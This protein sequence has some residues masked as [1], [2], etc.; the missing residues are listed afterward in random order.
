MT[1]LELFR[2]KA[3]WMLDSLKGGKVKKYLNE[4]K[5]IEGEDG[6]PDKDV[7]SYC[8]SLLK[9][10]LEHAGKTVPLYSGQKTLNIQDWP[11]T[12]KMTYREDYDKC[13]SSD[14]DKASLIEMSTSGSTGTPF[15][16][17]Q[18]GTKKKHVNA[19][20][21]FY[22]GKIGFE[23]GRRI[24]YLRSIVSEVQKSRLTQFLQNIYLLDCGDL[25]DEGIKKKL[26]RIVD[27][28]KGCGAMMMG[29]ASTF[30][31]FRRYFDKYGFKDA[32]GAKIYGIASGSEMLY[33]TTRASMEKAF[34]CKCVSRYANEENGFLGQDSKENN[35][36]YLNRADYYF[37]IL[38]MDE[39]VPAEENEIGRI[40]V[41]DLFNYAMP[42]IR[43]DT[44]DVGA[45]V[46]DEKTGRKLLGSFGGRKV[47]TITDSRGN[48][49]SP[50]SITNKMW[51]H[52]DIKQYQFVQKDKC[53]YKLI[54]NPGEEGVDEAKLKSDMLGI[55][56]EDSII[57]IEYTKDIP[58]LSSGK[59]RYIVNEMIGK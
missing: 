52:K 27:L 39:D 38:K 19:E 24:I 54:I 59:R 12:N 47:D 51:E 15:K 55:L 32:E 40:V 33:D 34:G 23:I 14:F 4:L 42:M 29:Y 48:I 18:N 50:H 43:Y 8:D 21:L 3:F 5:R 35:I 9:K 20:T 53:R 28:S 17:F 22:N 6:L 7:E 1:L 16:S 57:S 45:F 25:S 31:A 49:I 26:K 37:E 56:G 46:Y 10:L 44:G 41:T 11:V 58:V 36:F 13:I 30:D 2:N